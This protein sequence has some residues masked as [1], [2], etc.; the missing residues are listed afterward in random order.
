MMG[1]GGELIPRLNPSCR[2]LKVASTT[3]TPPISPVGIKYDRLRN[4][5]DILERAFGPGRPPPCQ[6]PVP[7]A[8]KL[9]CTQS[10]GWRTITEQASASWVPVDTSILLAPPGTISCA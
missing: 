1:P 5:Q 4:R 8:R 9:A 10:S 2:R 7:F 6:P 3:S